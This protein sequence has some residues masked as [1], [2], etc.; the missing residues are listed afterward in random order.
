MA[1]FPFNFRP[2]AN[3]FGNLLEMSSTALGTGGTTVANSATTTVIIPTPNTKAYVDRIS[4]AGLVA[5]VSTGAVTV[6]FFKQSGAT[7]TALTNTLS[8]RNDV[9]TAAT[10]ATYAVT[11]TASD[12]VR[13]IQPGD[14]V[15]CDVV[16]AGT[17]STQ[18]TVTAQC[19]LSI[20]S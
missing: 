15:I 13:L 4:V 16:A 1:T 10:A 3:R 14:C 17:V 6:Q 18:P 11:I 2:L 7:K 19:T 20:I 8:I 5:A 9:I 12:V